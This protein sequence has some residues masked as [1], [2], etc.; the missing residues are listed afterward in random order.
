MDDRALLTHL[1]SVAVA[2]ADPRP[3]IAAQLP[4]PPK[5]RTFV[6]GAGKGS[7]EMALAFEAAW[8][9]AGHRIDAGLVAVRHGTRVPTRAIRIVEAAHPV[10]DEASFSAARAMLALVEDAGPDDL[11]VALVSGGGSAL[12][13]L[14]PEGIAPEEKREVNR[15]LLACGASIHEIN[16][17][18]KH[19]SRVKGG[20]LAAAA[21]PARVVSFVVSDI[22]GDDVAIVASGPTVPSEATRA[23][24]LDIVS[25]YRLDLPA[26]MRAH[27]ESPDAE[28]PRPGAAFAGD[29]VITLATAR[30]S[31]DAA[32]RA[33]EAEGLAAIVLSDRIEGEARDIGRMHGALARETVERGL[34]PRPCVL[35]SGGETSVTLRAPGGRGGRNTEFLLGLAEAID[36]VPGLLALAADTDG[37]DGSEANAGAFCDGASA[38]ALRQR[39]TPLAGFLAANDA[40]GAFAALGTLFSPGPTGTNV[41]DFRAILVR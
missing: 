19:L 14:P 12:L 11:V 37:I 4:A 35:L 26:A 34:F 18:R 30:N 15:R 16:A 1:F 25:R 23:E 36:G 41:N 27:L 31:L 13:A 38:G 21:H 2:A 8:L 7:G 40:Y 10:P 22:P 3:G 9:E 33:A 20:R 29:A 28:A 24:A 17:V 39:G 32:R 5:G 6:V